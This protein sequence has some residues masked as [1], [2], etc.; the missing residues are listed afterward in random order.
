LYL[1]IELVSLL[2]PCFDDV[3]RQAGPSRDLVIHNTTLTK[4]LEKFAEVRLFDH[5]D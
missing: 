2:F 5:V 1:L 4:V 3:F